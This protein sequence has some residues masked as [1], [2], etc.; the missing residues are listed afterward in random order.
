MNEN[1]IVISGEE[2]KYKVI[3]KKI[4]HIYFKWQDDTLIISCNNYISLKEIKL[5]I[6]SNEKKIYSLIRKNENTLK[7][8]EI[9][10]LGDVYKVVFDGKSSTFIEGNIITSMNQDELN[11]YLNNF[12]KGVFTARINALK[13]QFKDLPD[14]H[15][16][17]RKM[18]SRW[19]VCNIKSMSVTLN[20]ELIKKDV[21]LIDYV[22]IHE[23]C[24]FKHMNHSK[25]FW[26]EVGKY[27]PYY[28]L[29]RKRLREER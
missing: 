4:K 25:S 15:L 7:D 19:G 24:H 16:K 28:K 21:T 27:Y 9:M 10:L 29:A 1:Y 26:Q 20:S 22:I 18:K 2:V 6:K 12:C 14:F 5:L 11:K 13:E 23:L 17:I 8:D 3:R